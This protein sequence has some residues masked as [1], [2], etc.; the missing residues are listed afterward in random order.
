VI[1][2]AADLELA[3]YLEDQS[4]GT[5]G[6]D[7]F[8]GTMPAGVVNAIGITQYPGA[9]PELTCGSDGWTM[10]VSRLQVRVRNADE[11]TAL[12]K[13][14]DAAEAL[15]KVANQTIESVRYRAVT[16][17]Q[18]PGL[19]ERDASNNTVVGFNIEA[20]KVPS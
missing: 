19:L 9:P 14:K 1:A 8:A 4:V 15:T 2:M 20:E 12:S 3:E 10:E 17:L 5:V 16:V 18:S 11:A 6:A 13:A 7:L